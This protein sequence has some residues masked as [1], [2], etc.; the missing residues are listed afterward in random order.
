MLLCVVFI[1]CFILYGF[2]QCVKL[3][4]SVCVL[5]KYIYLHLHLCYFA[6]HEIMLNGFTLALTCL[7]FYTHININEIYTLT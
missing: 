5:K 3:Y 1:I 4:K 7:E 2:T 6:Q